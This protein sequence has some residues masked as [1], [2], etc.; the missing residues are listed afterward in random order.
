[1]GLL[2]TKQWIG[3]TVASAALLGGGLVGCSSADSSDSPDSTTGTA[4]ESSPVAPSDGPSQFPEERQTVPP[5][6]QPTSEPVPLDETAKVRKG[7]TV[8][9]ISE[10]P[11]NIDAEGP[12]ESSGP[13]VLLTMRIQNDSTSTVDLKNVIVDMT[14]GADATPADPALIPGVEPLVGELAPGEQATGD[15]AFRIPK[16]QRDDVTISVFVTV[17]DPVVVFT[18]ALS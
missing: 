6:E 12:G 18:G 2:V 15:Y 17:D 16:S 1:M 14:Y 7:V 11:I 10:K 5:R 4:V 8:K 13:G 9:L 3:V